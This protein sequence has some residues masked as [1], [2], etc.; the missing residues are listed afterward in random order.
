MQYVKYT[1]CSALTSLSTRFQAKIRS[2][3]SKGVFFVCFFLLNNCTQLKC[4][5]VIE[6]KYFGGWLLQ[7]LNSFFEIS[8]AYTY[9]VYKAAV[10][11]FFIYF[12]CLQLEDMVS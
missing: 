5:W 1:C 2:G 4:I 6:K 7:L 12:C 11:S 10:S 9:F 8:F 3:P